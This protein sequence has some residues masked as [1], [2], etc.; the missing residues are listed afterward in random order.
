MRLNTSLL[1]WRILLDRRLLKNKM[2]IEIFT[3]SKTEIHFILIRNFF[4][5]TY[6]IR[7]SVKLS[8]TPSWR[9]TRRFSPISLQDTKRNRSCIINFTLHSLKKGQSLGISAE[10]VFDWLTIKLCIPHW[11]RITISQF[12][13][14]QVCKPIGRVVW[15]FNWCNLSSITLFIIIFHFND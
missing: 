5:A 13:L 2:K 12:M 4:H 1:I 15:V 6:K 11:E 14:L 7:K 9:S 8:K 3:K 10:Y